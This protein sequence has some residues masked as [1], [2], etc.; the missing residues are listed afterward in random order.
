MKQLNGSASQI[1][2]VMNWPILILGCCGDSNRTA[3][4]VRLTFPAFNSED[5]PVILFG[6]L[7]QIG[8][9][10]I[11]A[12]DEKS[13]HVDLPKSTVVSVT[14]WRDEWN[15]SDWQT[16]VRGPVKFVA[17]AWTKEG[18]SD[19]FLGAPWNR[20]WK[21]S[22]VVSVNLRTLQPW[23]SFSELLMLRSLDFCDLQGRIPFTFILEPMTVRLSLSG[24][25]FGF[26][27][28]KSE[29]ML[30]AA[31]SSF[32]LG[33]IRS[34]H[35]QTSKVLLRLGDLVSSCRIVDICRCCS[36]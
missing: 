31:N 15:P 9:K 2:L 36:N 27:Q 33:L 11:T 1:W 29:V 32:Y 12:K 3:C 7:H 24:W 18:H 10:A 8:S 13:G 21:D 14:L 4:T 19:F 25:Q 35:R 28:P 30:K 16:V 22:K 5:Q 17:N 6:C 34:C 26:N 20:F 23:V